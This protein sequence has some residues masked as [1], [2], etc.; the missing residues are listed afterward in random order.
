VQVISDRIGDA[1]ALKMCYGALNKGTQALWLEVLIAAHRLGVDG[2]LD[3][4]LQQSQ[5][6]LYQ[7]ALGQFPALPPKAFRW[8]P[9]MLE[10]SKTLA[11]AG[12]NPQVFQGA[13]DIYRFVAGTALGKETP[14]NRDKGREGKDVVRLLAQERSR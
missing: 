1:S 12:M 4:Q 13:A 8:A 9:E 11:T 10:I 3:Q 14:E 7:W 5:A 6:D 2:L